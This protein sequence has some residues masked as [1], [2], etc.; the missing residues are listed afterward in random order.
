V[1]PI[2]DCPP[3]P[4]DGASVFLTGFGSAPAAAAHSAKAGNFGQTCS[5]SRRSCRRRRCSRIAGWGTLSLATNSRYRVRHTTL[6]N[7]NGDVRCER[8]AGTCLCDRRSDCG[9]GA[10]H[11]ERS[12]TGPSLP[13]NGAPDNSS[14]CDLLTGPSRVRGSGMSGSWANPR[15]QS[16]SSPHGVR[17]TP[18]PFGLLDEFSL[19]TRRRAPRKCYFELEPR[20]D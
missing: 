13:W 3:L 10:S 12:A 18:I 7:I 6:I 20:L 19:K 2:N 4:V 11:R 17:Q 16:C 14:I 1:E 9:A 8:P 15:L 5:S